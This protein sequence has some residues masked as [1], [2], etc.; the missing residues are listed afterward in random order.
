MEHDD[1]RL[2]SDQARNVY[3]ML[4]WRQGF[5][6]RW[7]TYKSRRG[8][9]NLIRMRCSFKEVRRK[10]QGKSVEEDVAK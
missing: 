7:T 3:E 8:T 4:V 5:G 10:G 9:G 6:G 2:G 1:S